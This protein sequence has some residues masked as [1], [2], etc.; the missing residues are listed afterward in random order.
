MTMVIMT[1]T[2]TRTT[3][4]QVTDEPLLAEAR[5]LAG[6]KHQALDEVLGKE[7]LGHLHLGLPQA[8]AEHFQRQ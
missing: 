3:H 6:H 8:V 4:L 7:L 2:M 5:A 1:M